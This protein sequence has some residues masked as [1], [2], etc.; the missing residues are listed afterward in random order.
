[1]S[2]V[3]YAICILRIHNIIIMYAINKKIALCVAA[4]YKFFFVKHEN[5]LQLINLIIQ[6]LLIFIYEHFPR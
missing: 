2:F 4:K 3:L 6:Y 5:I 1:M